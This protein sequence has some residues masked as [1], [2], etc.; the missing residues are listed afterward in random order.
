MAE[1]NPFDELRKTLALPSMSSRL[2]AIIL[3]A[4]SYD[5]A[6]KLCAAMDGTLGRTR[7]GY[8]K[9]LRDNELFSGSLEWTHSYDRLRRFAADYI[10]RHAG[11]L[12]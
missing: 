1:R 6:L 2:A 12:A 8:E 4:V 10:A 5:Q 7:Q 11:S 3:T 9:L